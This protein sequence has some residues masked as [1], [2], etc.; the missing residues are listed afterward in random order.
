M[1]PTFYWQE[2]RI[3]AH[4][5][6]CFTAYMLLPHLHYRMNLSAGDLERMS[7]TAIWIICLVCRS[8]VKA[9]SSGRKF[10]VFLEGLIGVCIGG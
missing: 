6:I 8:Q 3:K 1:R 7:P 2:E 5:A 4:V 9:G 10:A